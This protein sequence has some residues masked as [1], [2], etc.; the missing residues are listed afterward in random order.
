MPQPAPSWMPPPQVNSD[1]SDAMVGDNEGANVAADVVPSEVASDAH[2]SDAAVGDVGNEGFVPDDLEAPDDVNVPGDEDVDVEP[3][4]EIQTADHEEVLPLAVHDDVGLE[5]VGDPSMDGTPQASVVN[6]PAA[7]ALVPLHAILDEVINSSSLNNVPNIP[8][9]SHLNCLITNLDT[10]VP[11]YLAKSD[12]V[13]HLAKVLV[14]PEPLEEEPEVQVLDKMQPVKT[15]RKRQAR[16]PRGPVDVKFLR[17]RTRLSSDLHGF[18][19]QASASAALM[20][21]AP[22]PVD[23]PRDAPPV[24]E[25]VFIPNYEAVPSSA[26]V[27]T[28]HLPVA[29]LQAMGTGFLKM[30]SE[31]VSAEA[32]LESD[33]E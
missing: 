27:P 16:K 14:D 31:M 23:V 15:P 8:S 30:P 19:D 18:K 20:R 4:V 1:A 6:S 29:T 28:P 10:M 24:T 17:R 25:D 7:S 3:S 32:L 9:F 12:I 11:A 5:V 21:Q 33:D 26:I 13:W 2:M 22:S